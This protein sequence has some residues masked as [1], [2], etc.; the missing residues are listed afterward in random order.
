MSSRLQGLTPAAVQLIVATAQALEAGRSDHAAEMLAGVLASNP[1]HPEALRLE[2][3]ILSL[4]G[5]HGDAVRAMRR[6]IVQRLDDALYHNTMGTVLAAAGHMDGAI[7]ALR[8]ACMLQP[9]LAIGWYNL[10]IMLIRGV[11]FDEAAVALQRAVALAPDHMLARAQLADMLKIGGRAEDAAVEYRKVIAEHP[12]VGI[13]WWGL[14]DIKT[15]RFTDKDIPRMRSALRDPRASDDDLITLG[16]AL[17][18]ALDDEKLYA[19]SLDALASANAVARRHSVWDAPAFSASI[20]AINAAFEPFRAQAPVGLGREVI[21]IVGLPRSGSTLVE[22]ILASHSLVEGAGELLDLPQ[23]LSDESQRRRKP[24]AQWAAEMSA[25]DW[26]R[27]G[28]HYL[29]RTAHWRRRRPMFTDKLPGNWPYLGAIR[30]MLPGAHIISCR[31]DPLETCLG[32][33]RQHMAGNAYTRTFTDLASYWRVFDRTVRHWSTAHP[34]HVREHSYEELLA[35]PPLEIRTLLDFLGLPFE[36]A[37]LKFHETVRDVRSPS[38]MQV[39]QPLRRDTARAL[40]YGSLL[41]PLRDALGMPP[42]AA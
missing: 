35:D 32:C 38:A 33:Y 1:D 42:F 19:E 23:V 29:Q 34:K 24:F 17:A 2:A 7:E 15:M 16:F 18:K 40:R 39:R 25:E 22:Q 3:G 11:R 4:R 6:A 41:D 36:D 27:L 5:R 9:S 13:A 26:E 10:G 21:F 12:W 37:C 14:A 30:A 8:H 28:N 20:V 31:R